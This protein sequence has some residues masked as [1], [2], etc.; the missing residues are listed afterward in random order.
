MLRPEVRMSCGGTQERRIFT[1]WDQRLA[2]VSADGGLCAPR[3]KTRVSFFFLDGSW[4]KA[5]SS[6]LRVTLGTAFW[7]IVFLTVRGKVHQ[8]SLGTLR[9]VQLY[10]PQWVVL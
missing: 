10:L 5:A 3:R 1:W 8:P 7:S 2:L 4:R 6:P 9:R